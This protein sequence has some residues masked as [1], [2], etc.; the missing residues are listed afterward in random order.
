M[1][2]NLNVLVSNIP[3]NL[4]VRLDNSVYFKVGDVE[5]LSSKLNEKLESNISYDY[6]DKIKN[7]Y[8]WDIICE[9]LLD[10]YKNK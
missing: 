7:S 9:Q 5:E 2:Y 4:E 8:N 6:T 1:S 3:A 10:V